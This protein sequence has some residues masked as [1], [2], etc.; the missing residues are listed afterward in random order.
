MRAIAS[1]NPSPDGSSLARSYS[2]MAFSAG[3]SEWKQA[4]STVI[5]AG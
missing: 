4:S 3:F 2:A 5:S 1:C